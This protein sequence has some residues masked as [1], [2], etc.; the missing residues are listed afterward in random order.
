MALSKQI[1]V[2]ETVAH[3]AILKY[4]VCRPLLQFPLTL[5]D[6]L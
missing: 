3:L 5:F 2:E 1:S 4:K 6:E